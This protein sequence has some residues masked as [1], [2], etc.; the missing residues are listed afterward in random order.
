MSESIN[1]TRCGKTNLPVDGV[2][3]CTPR[4]AD[5]FVEEIEQLKLDR[6]RLLGGL[7]DIAGTYSMGCGSDSM[8]DA[9]DDVRLIAKL[10]ITEIE[11][12]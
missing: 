11:N 6:E 5:S 2:H 12:A 1:C 9:L 10:L 8:A 7:R 4:M 3:T